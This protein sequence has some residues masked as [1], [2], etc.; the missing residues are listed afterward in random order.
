M[1]ATGQGFL[2]PTSVA[3]SFPWGRYHG[4]PWGRN[5]NEGAVDWPPEP[6][7]ILRAFYATWRARAP[8]LD[9]EVVA[10]LLDALAEPP[11]FAVPVHQVAH[12]RHYY[13]DI[14]QGPLSRGGDVDKVFDPFAVFERGAKLYVS[15]PVDLE[16][17]QR[18]A[19]AVLCDRLTYLGRAESVCVAELEDNLRSELPDGYRQIRPGS[20]EEDSMLCDVLAAERPLE[21][22]HLEVRPQRLRGSGRLEP[23]GSRRVT[24]PAVP[25]ETPDQQW[26]PHR[27]AGSASQVTAVRLSLTS[28]ALPSRH[29]AVLVADLLRQQVVRILDPGGSGRFSVSLLGKNGR[30]ERQDTDHGH[31]H[32]VPLAINPEEMGLLD[33]VVV[34]APAGLDADDIGILRKIELLKNRDLRPCLVGIEGTGAVEEV[35]PEIYGPARRWRSFTPYAPPRHVRRQPTWIDHALACLQRDLGQAHLAADGI[36][37]IKGPW[38]DFRRY[39]NPPRE[40]LRHARRVTGFQLTFNEPV[41][42][43]ICLGALRH[44]GLGLFLP[45]KGGPDN[46]Q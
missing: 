38:L 26:S 3:I 39:R 33:T 27:V 35:A 7:R 25:E 37:V 15:W 12:T 32:Y 36:E 13:P 2:M 1:A 43:P 28:N 45:V 10:S 29:A 20:G 21:L 11:E 14:K 46:G 44:F 17:P 22:E 8:E 42:G 19:L 9:G 18:A 34:W 30:G 23:V 4:T 40:T 5:I 16:E 31:A 41:A 24:Y 6:W